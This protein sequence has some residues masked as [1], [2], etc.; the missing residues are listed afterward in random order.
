MSVHSPHPHRDVRGGWE[1]THCKALGAS[2]SLG[3]KGS[4][5]LNWAKPTETRCRR[6][7]S[8]V[9]SASLLS[10]SL[11]QDHICR[12]DSHRTE[13]DE[14]STTDSCTSGWTDRGQH[15]VALL[16]PRG[17]RYLLTLDGTLKFTPSSHFLSVTK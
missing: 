16:S 14:S 17:Y 10:Q 13:A 15:T 5:G 12:G 4:G 9:S 8:T 11:D 7:E 6:S 2:A 3:Q 1:R